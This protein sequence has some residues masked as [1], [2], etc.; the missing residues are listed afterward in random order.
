MLAHDYCEELTGAICLDSLRL[1]LLHETNEMRKR[2]YLLP[3]DSMVHKLPA[4]KNG[5]H[6][7]AAYYEEDFGHN[8]IFWNSDSKRIQSFWT[9]P[10]FQEIFAIDSQLNAFTQVNHKDLYKFELGNPD[11]R[12]AFNAPA[13]IMSEFAKVHQKVLVKQKLPK[14]TYIDVLHSEAQL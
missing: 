14:I 12:D 4:A 5:E 7:F 2:A 8:F 13:P 9:V 1:E 6:G 10:S 11:A 3:R